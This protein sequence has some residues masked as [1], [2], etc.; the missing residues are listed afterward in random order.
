MVISFSF[1]NIEQV[2]TGKKAY[3]KG[4]RCVNIIARYLGIMLQNL[5]CLL[6]VANNSFNV[7]FI[8]STA[9]NVVAKLSVNFLPSCYPVP[10]ADMTNLLVFTNFTLFALKHETAVLYP[11][12]TSSNYCLLSSK[13]TTIGLQ[14]V[15]WFSTMKHAFRLSSGPDCFLSMQKQTNNPRN[16]CFIGLYSFGEFTNDTLGSV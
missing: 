12:D 9:C 3:I 5:H 8:Y 6:I 14:W 10:N 13:M 15:Q 11:Q 2:K 16:Q 7:S 1:L 4:W